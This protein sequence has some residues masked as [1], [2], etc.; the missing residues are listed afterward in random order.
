MKNTSRPLPCPTC[1]SPR[2]SYM[3]LAL[4]NDEVTFPRCRQPLALT[5]NRSC[6]STHFSVMHRFCFTLLFALPRSRPQHLTCRHRQFGILPGEFTLSRQRR[7]SAVVGRRPCRMT[8]SPP[9]S[10]TDV[11]LSSSDPQVV[12][13]E[14]GIAV[15]V[16]DGRRI[17]TATIGDG[18]TAT[19]K[20]TVVGTRRTITLEFPQ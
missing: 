2:K 17:I 8:A 1:R 7:P 16:G 4:R 13:I 12:T 6:L 15:A 19:A 14:D 5:L 20:V 9:R 10:P 3:C 11:E 18:N